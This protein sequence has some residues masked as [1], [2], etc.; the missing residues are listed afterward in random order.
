MKK[1]IG[2][3]AVDSGTIIIADPCY[4]VPEKEDVHPEWAESHKGYSEIFNEMHKND[5]KCQIQ[6]ANLVVCDIAGTAVISHTGYGDGTYP[7]YADLNK[8]GRV[9][10]LTIKFV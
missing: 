8:E 2:H 5:P 4:I 1:L 7:V 10:S 6:H 3:C 9:K